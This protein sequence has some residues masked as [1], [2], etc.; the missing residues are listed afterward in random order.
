MDGKYG[1][2]V[3][4]PQITP[5][6]SRRLPP[7]KSV[8]V[9]AKRFRQWYRTPYQVEQGAA[10]GVGRLVSKHT[11]L[12]QAFFLRQSVINPPSL[13]VGGMPLTGGDNRRNRNSQCGRGLALD[14]SDILKRASWVCR[15]ETHATHSGPGTGPQSSCPSS[16]LVYRTRALPPPNSR[17]WLAGGAGDYRHRVG[18]QHAA[19]LLAGGEALERKNEDLKSKIKK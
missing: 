16:G 2:P 12:V 4:R 1:R 13:S 9:E 3:R 7:D 5:T 8:N 15:T 14:S 10:E 19:A 11:C 6:T 17:P 18:R